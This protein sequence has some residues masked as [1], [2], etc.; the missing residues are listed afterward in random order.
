MLDLEFV[1]FILLI[2]SFVMGGGRE[3]VICSL[4]VCI[5]KLLFSY[6]MT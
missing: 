6:L 1:L 5:D 2:F 3:V 4:T